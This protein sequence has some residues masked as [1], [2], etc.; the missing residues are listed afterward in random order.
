MKKIY[1]RIWRTCVGG[2][3][4]GGGIP[5]LIPHSDFRHIVMCRIIKAIDHT[6][7]SLTL[8]PVS[9]PATLLFMTPHTISTLVYKAPHLTADHFQ[10]QYKTTNVFLMLSLSNPGS[11]QL[12]YWRRYAVNDGAKHNPD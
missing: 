4:E 6:L 8:P 5:Q 11:R 2:E 7:G 12:L 1:Y 10:S 9:R 3:K